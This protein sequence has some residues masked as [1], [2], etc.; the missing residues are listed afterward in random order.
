MA[1]KPTFTTSQITTQLTTS[2][3]GTYTGYQFTWVS[4]PNVPITYS[5]NTATPTNSGAAPKE[6]GASLVGMSPTQ[7]ATAHLAFQLWADLMAKP[8]VE[9]TIPAANITLDY[10]S[11]TGNSTYTA[12]FGS[13]NST[14][15][16]VSLGAE[17]V[18][19]ATTWA[20]NADSG[21]ALGAYGLLTMVHEIG[22]ALGL[23]H[24]GVYNAGSGG[25]ITYA[26]NAAFAQDNRQYTVM[27]YFG[28]YLPGSG[29]QQDGTFTNYIYPQTPMV[30]DIAAKRLQESLKRLSNSG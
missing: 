2:W 3:G 30:Y 10:S 17:Q 5:I 20:S 28:G 1:T 26:T 9:S 18:W 16:T 15:K 24:P 4:A 7:V 21:M 22:H 23:S 19:M 12:P 6:G 8:L 13:V 29:W 25:T 14:T 27:S 11:N